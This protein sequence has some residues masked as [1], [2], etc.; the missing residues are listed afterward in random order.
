MRVL[1]LAA[2]HG[3]RLRPLTDTTPKCLVTIAGK[4]LLDYWL[5]RLFAV[6]DVER[7]LINTHWLAD[8]VRAHAAGSDFADRID[9]VHETTLLGPG[10]TVVANR[11]WLG[12]GPVLV[13][14]A[15]NL[16]SFDLPSFIAD[17]AARAP[18]CA[19]SMLAFRPDTPKSCGILELDTEGVVV[20]FHE[21]VESPPGNLANAAVYLMEREVMDYAVGL[22]RPVVDLSTEVIPAFLG[23]I[24]SVETDG[25]HRDIGTPES[26]AQAEKDFGARP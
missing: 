6:P 23:R 14:H 7:V 10:G 9:L 25:Y 19:M 11:T 3:T 12:D 15:A 18:R 26:L 4:P 13:A 20:A 2:G 17:H 22:G 16:T 8:Q 1:L 5:E 24:Q 21:K